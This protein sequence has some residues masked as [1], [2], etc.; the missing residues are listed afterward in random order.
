VDRDCRLAG[1]EQ[2]GP[3]ELRPHALDALRG[4]ALLDERRSG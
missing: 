4:E 1:V 2:S 3:E